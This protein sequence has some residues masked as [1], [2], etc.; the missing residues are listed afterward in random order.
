[1][2]SFWKRVCVSEDGFVGRS[3][4]HVISPMLLVGFTPGAP[5]V[6]DANKFSRNHIK[7]AHGFIDC[8]NDI[9][10][11]F[12]IFSSQSAL[13]LTMEAESPGG[14]FAEQRSSFMRSLFRRRPFSPSYNRVPEHPHQ[15]ISTLVDLMEDI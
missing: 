8:V 2:F 15:K 13:T 1:M 4:D 9:I 12:F 11:F 7:A 6:Y 5:V 10:L 14:F 3:L